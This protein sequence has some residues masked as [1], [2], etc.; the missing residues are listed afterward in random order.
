MCRFVAGNR[1]L[2]GLLFVHLRVG[3]RSKR[4]QLDY[5]LHFFRIPQT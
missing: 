3:L 2:T 5:D 4:S 1:V